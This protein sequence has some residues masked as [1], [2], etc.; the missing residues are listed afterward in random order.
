[1]SLSKGIHL[2]AN[3]ENKRPLHFQEVGYL[4]NPTTF[5]PVWLLATVFILLYVREK[6][7]QKTKNKQTNKKTKQTGMLKFC[8][9]PEI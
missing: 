5:S 7:P 1:M 4:W 3:I 2:V 6:K 8:L 9:C